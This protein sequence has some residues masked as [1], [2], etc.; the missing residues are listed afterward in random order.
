[1]TTKEYIEAHGYKVSDLT[2]KEIKEIEKEVESINAGYEV[3]D[4]FFTKKIKEV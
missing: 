1:M 3:I 2:E 4:G